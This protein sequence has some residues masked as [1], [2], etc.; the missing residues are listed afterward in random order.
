MGFPPGGGP[1]TRPLR[2]PGQKCRSCSELVG[3]RCLA[4]TTWK[5]VRWRV[6]RKSYRWKSYG[7]LRVAM[8]ETELRVGQSYSGTVLQIWYYC[9]GCGSGPGFR[10]SDVSV[11]EQGP[12]Q[13]LFLLAISGHTL[14]GTP[15]LLPACSC[16]C[17]AWPY[18][19]A[20]RVGRVSGEHRAHQLQG[21]Y[22][23][24]MAQMQMPLR[25]DG[26]TDTAHTTLWAFVAGLGSMEAD[27]RLTCNHYVLVGTPMACWPSRRL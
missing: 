9:L 18:D 3:P 10:F 26:Q 1:W 21:R 17:Q 25:H 12:S 20:R 16:G 2:T 6:G 5:L 8:G 27:P 19:D 11:P 24:T 7:W 15:R 4:D 13:N 22:R 14:R 23:R